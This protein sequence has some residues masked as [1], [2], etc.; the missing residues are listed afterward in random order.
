MLPFYQCFVDCVAANELIRTGCVT[1]G[2]IK[3]A[4]V[5]VPQSDESVSK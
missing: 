4:I 1:L 2:E 5:A 3:C